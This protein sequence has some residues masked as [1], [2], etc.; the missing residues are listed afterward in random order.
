MARI[1]AKL[2]MPNIRMVVANPTV[3]C[4]NPNVRKFE[5]RVPTSL[6]KIDIRN[7]LESV[8]DIRI[9]KVNTMVVSGKWK[10]SRF[11]TWYQRPDYKKAIVTYQIQPTDQLLL[12]P[13]TTDTEKK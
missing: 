13:P 5:V 3:Q 8:Y 6:G 7:Y 11:G 2:W 12:P 10:R 4:P 1:P 9:S